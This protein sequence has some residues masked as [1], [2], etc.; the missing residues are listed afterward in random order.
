MATHAPVGSASSTAPAGPVVAVSPASARTYATLSAAPIAGSLGAE[1]T[2]IDLSA[3][4]SDQQVADIRAAAVDHL[5]V[6]FRDQTFPIDRQE[7]LTRRLGGFGETPF[8][9]QLAGHDGVVR[10]VKEA[11]E[12]G[13]ANFG[14][15][16]H[17]DWSFQ[18]AP[19]AFTLLY[20]VDVP[21]YGGDTLWTN[22]ILAYETLSAGLRATLDTLRTVHSARRSYAPGSHIDRTADRRSM[23]ITASD[24]AYAEQEHPLVVTHPESGKRALYLNPTYTIRIA[25]W[26]AE[27]S[28][29][30]LD[31]LATHATQPAFTC[32]FRWTANTLAIWDNRVT[33]HNAI[34][35]YD[36]HRREAYRTTVAGTP[37][38]S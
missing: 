15:G 35:D 33:Q 31:F 38:R 7:E 1:I 16:W 30:L 10:V 20:A 4:L 2:G 25:G 8:V 21:P 28:K 9:E 13:I 29:P 17:T 37:P 5:V 14:G 32:R 12:T 27:E 34:N 26:N 22:G 3:P 6:F 18:A 23:R 24:E 19:P 36:G 11:H